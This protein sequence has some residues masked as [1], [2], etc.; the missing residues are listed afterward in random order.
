MTEE[1]VREL[2][3]ALIEN[4]RAFVAEE[5][6]KYYK[7]GKTVPSKEIEDMLKAFEADHMTK[8]FNE[9]KIPQDKFRVFLQRYLRLWFDVLAA[10]INEA[11]SKIIEAGSV[12]DLPVDGSATL[13]VVGG[14]L[15]YFD[16]DE[17]KSVND[18]IGNI[19]V[20]PDAD[21]LPDGGA[22]QN[23][24]IAGEDLYF[25]NGN[26]W[27]RVVTE[28]DL[29]TAINNVISYIDEALKNAGGERLRTYHDTVLEIVDTLPALNEGDRYLLT[30]GEDEIVETFK[31]LQSS[32]T[33]EY[34]GYSRLHVFSDDSALWGGDDKSARLI[35]SQNNKTYPVSG[36]TGKVTCVK[37]FNEEIYFVG[38]SSL[39]LFDKANKS[40]KTVQTMTSR[41]EFQRSPELYDGTVIEYSGKVYTLVGTKLYLMNFGAVTTQTLI[42][43]NLSASGEYA[44]G[45]DGK[46]Y[47]TG[48]WKDGLFCL[49]SNGELRQIEGSEGRIYR[50]LAKGADNKLYC[51]CYEDWKIY[52][53][54]NG[55]LMP[56]ISETM[57]ISGS[58]VGQNGKVYFYNNAD[59]SPVYVAHNGILASTGI[60]GN[61]VRTVILPDDRLYFQAAEGP[62]YYLEYDETVKQS[63]ITSPILTGIVNAPNGKSY[64]IGNTSSGY[65]K[66]LYEFDVST[67][68]RLVSTAGN[69]MFYK[70]YLAPD[71]NLYVCMD[72]SEMKG[73]PGIS[74][75]GAIYRF[76]YEADTL[77]LI[78]STRLT[79]SDVRLGPDGKLYVL[80]YNY[81]GE[82]I[83]EVGYLEN[84][85]LKPVSI[86][87]ARGIGTLFSGTR[88]EKFYVNTKDTF[89][90]LVPVWR[91][92][93]VAVLN[94]LHE[95]ENKLFFNRG[96]ENT[97]QFSYIGAS[98]D[99]TWG[100]EINLSTE[101]ANFDHV[102]AVYN[103][104]LHIFGMNT[105]LYVINAGSV[106]PV[107]VTGTMFDEPNVKYKAAHVFNSLLYVGIESVSYNRTR[108]VVAW[109]GS[110]ATPCINVTPVSF[111]P[112]IVYFG[113]DSSELY[114]LSDGSGGYLWKLTAGTFEPVA[115]LDGL[116]SGVVWKG[117]AY[118]SAGEDLLS[119]ELVSPNS[120]ATVFDSIVTVPF[121]QDGRLLFIKMGWNAGEGLTGQYS[122]QELTLSTVT[123]GGEIKIVGRNDSGQY[124][125]PF[126]EGH[127]VVV[128]DSPTGDS[129]E[130]GIRDGSLTDTDGAQPDWNQPDETA[131][132]F[133]KNKPV[134]PPDLTD[135]VNALK[136][137]TVIRGNVDTYA[138]LL[139]VDTAGMRVND[140]YIVEQDENHGGNSSIYTWDGAA[141]NFTHIWEINLDLKY[142][143]YTVSSTPFTFDK[144]AA[145]N[146]DSEEFDVLEVSFGDGTAYDISIST[147]SG[148]TGDTRIMIF[149]VAGGQTVNL[150]LGFAYRLVDG[151]ELSL[152]AGIHAVTLLRGSTNL[153]NTAPYE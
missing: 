123:G 137:I 35:F 114:A 4:F 126:E 69:N 3:D 47:F 30:A 153:I 81:S 62:W 135:E 147:A 11:G 7:M 87:D 111:D 39:C 107:P 103:G 66:G 44:I 31:T 16:G 12:D 138:H 55:V 82:D 110:A 46:P 1:E 95:F 101:A 54:A 50:Y 130:Y 120:V 140:S 61:F 146:E 117:K 45:G 59:N 127:R 125:E 13:A 60:T 141:W 100:S 15:Y 85:S 134:I 42:G 83:R 53:L 9:D 21:M 139:D 5:V 116:G 86:S 88:Y 10:K 105:G 32:A 65:N 67:G 96:S 77:E 71:E 121:V 68:V 18:L 79:R 94:G 8:M 115:A 72:G 89:Y 97:A 2:L 33:N 124:E 152:S 133:I 25:W 20:Y 132:D 136:S 24:A 57:D 112:D 36:F 148:K 84:G 113:E 34:N 74:Q 151:G 58:A 14:E 40:A 109:N 108:A 106:M 22:G 26:E 27:V 91:Q 118:Y 51:Y 143:T 128:I 48:R 104:K 23:I 70:I 93:V 76:N 122:I 98:G 144:F 78:H 145:K 73:T 80:D 149:N 129:R 75:L 64:A 28:K 17:W 102:T 131:I 41:W 38:N 90:F 142:G 99:I 52:C 63:N 19:P 150:T 6:Q 92:G 119:V 43:E 29:S 56:A 49:E 37:E